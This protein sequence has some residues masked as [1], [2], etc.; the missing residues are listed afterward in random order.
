MKKYLYIYVAAVALI[1][2][3]E[4][5]SQVVD[6]SALQRSMIIEREYNPIVRDAS[7]INTL[8]QVDTPVPSKSAAE[9]SP[10][11]TFRESA[12]MPV[13]V[14][15]SA[16]A[17]STY[18][19]T[20][21]IGYLNFAGGNYMN[22]RGSAG[23]TYE[24][25]RDRVGLTFDHASTN[26]DIEN[27]QYEGLKRKAKSMDN[28]GRLFYRHRFD[29]LDLKINLN[30]THSSFNYYGVLFD[31]RLFSAP[32]DPK[33]L[34]SQTHGNIKG[35]V[36]IASRSEEDALEYSLNVGYA[37]FNKSI[38]PNPLHT[39]SKVSEGWVF[40]NGGVSVPF[41]EVNRVGLDVDFNSFSYSNELP[42]A[43]SKRLGFGSYGVVGLNP[44]YNLGIDQLKMRLGARFEMGFN[45]GKSFMPSPD[46]KI[47][48][49]F[50]EGYTLFAHAGGGVEFLNFEAAD[51]MNRYISPMIRVDDE[52]VPVDGTF[53]IKGNVGYGFSFELFGGYKWYNNSTFFL[54]TADEQF[55]NTSTY[56]DLKANNF[57]VG[58]ILKYKYQQYVDLTVKLQKNNWSVNYRDEMEGIDVSG[59]EAKPF[60]K[61]DMEVNVGIDGHI[62]PE[63]SLSLNYYLGTNRWG[64]YLTDND[65]D[66]GVIL[67]GVKMDNINELSIGA[68][69][70]FM[71]HFTIN[72][73]VNNLLNA[74]YDYLY[75][76]PAQRLNFMVG[77]GVK[78]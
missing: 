30:Y 11:T 72:A 54:Q 43:D 62:T 73:K 6:T 39:N 75:G 7:K 2:I 46:V 38:F 23:L 33:R 4:L 19:F 1:F 68:Q 60:N 66:D 15:G 9:Y 8:P 28:I 41:Q 74:K 13:K 24:G 44:F 5:R 56:I 16:T 20:N 22:L 17:G 63:L 53:G 77:A 14:L 67:H 61:P 32:E 12:E 31:P 47:D 57:K 52:Y 3:P 69:Y 27:N 78:F 10:W 65:T 70:S 35:S 76:I 49:Q 42:E 51:R 50:T 25:E 18:P 37:H 45:K 58:G 71:K 64:G 34:E 26:G 59:M 40:M 36:G 21:Q 55:Y 29:P 48:W